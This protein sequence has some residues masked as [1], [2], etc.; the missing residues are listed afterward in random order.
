MPVREALRVLEQ[1]GLVEVSARRYTRV[2][3][4]RRAVADEAYPLLGLLESY[5]L[6]HMPVPPSAIGEARKANSA[7]AK[8]RDTIKRRR[9][10]VRFHRAITVSAPPIT[11]GVLSML[12]GRIALLE[13]GYHQTY[14]PAQSVSEHGD[15]LAALELG[16]VEAAARTVERHWARGYEAILPLLE[17]AEEAEVEGHRLQDPDS[18]SV[19]ETGS[20]ELTA[21]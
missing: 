7:L 20:G 17:D 12:Y 15:L 10:D 8:A 9:A 1:E 16:D 18:D 21:R 14:E 13:V 4:P 2:A 3:S 6:R 5:S 11:R 19:E